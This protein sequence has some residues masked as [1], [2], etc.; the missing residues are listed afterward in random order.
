MGEA[1][2]WAGPGGEADLLWNSFRRFS[3]LLGIQEYT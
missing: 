1:E 3:F 2:E